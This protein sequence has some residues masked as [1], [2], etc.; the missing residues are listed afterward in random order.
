M[1]AVAAPVSI[2]TSLG[3]RDQ[4]DLAG[5]TLNLHY[6]EDPQVSIH[7][8]AQRYGPQA[9]RS[10][11]EKLAERS[12]EARFEE[13]NLSDNQIGN[14]GARHL[15]QGLSGNAHVKRLILPRAGI[16]A[17]G[18]SHLGLL[19]PNLPALEVLVL[20]GNTCDAAGIQGS[21]SK[22]LSQNK[23]VRSLVVAAC[24]LGDKGGELLC[25]GIQAHPRLEHVG[26]SYNRLEAAVVPSLNKML[27][28]NQ[29]LRFLDLGGNSLGPAGAESLVEG[30]RANKGRI[31]QLG[32][33]KNGIQLR[34]AKALT[35]FFMTSEGHNLV[36]LDLRH[37]AI[38]YYGVADLRRQLGQPLSDDASDRG[39]MVLVGD[40]QILLDAH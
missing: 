15:Q 36:Y 4:V 16:G 17:E 30:L 3:A 39:W 8:C 24:R 32:L 13:L 29:G 37:N 21:F 27:S 25:E 33:S 31:R 11:F 34:G 14:D 35:T 23:S 22:G 6:V 5:T 18:F 20:S 28:V 12:L 19:L 40:R 7:Q 10:I 2:P 26:L 1:T 38:S 9:I